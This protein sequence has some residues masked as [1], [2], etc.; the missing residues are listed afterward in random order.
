MNQLSSIFRVR[1]GKLRVWVKWCDKLQNQYVAEVQKSLK[2]EKVES[3]IFY[4]I[5]FEDDYYTFGLMLFIGQLSEPKE[6]EYEWD[7]EHRR[8]IKECLIPYN[9]PDLLCL[10]AKK[11]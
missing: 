4:L 11:R 9:K 5:K 8:M 1:K 7:K 10:L 6:E 3:E 2:R